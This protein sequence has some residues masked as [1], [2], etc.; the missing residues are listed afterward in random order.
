MS[1]TKGFPVCFGSGVGVMN[2]YMSNISSR[3]KSRPSSSLGGSA[4]KSWDLPSIPRVNAVG[5]KAL[6]LLLRIKAARRARMEVF[7][8]VADV[9]F[10]EKMRCA[11][12]LV[13]LMLDD[14]PHYHHREAA[15]G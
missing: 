1:H 4:A 10:R 14:V 9:G 8:V 15:D 6:T 2:T 12:L 5:A 11:S 13:L 7:M 3:F